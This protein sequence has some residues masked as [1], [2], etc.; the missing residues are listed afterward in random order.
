M[1]V[2]AENNLCSSSS[3]PSAPL[4]LA[5]PLLHC[6]LASAVAVPCSLHLKSEMVT[7]VID[8][9]V[10]QSLQAWFSWRRVAHVLG[11]SSWEVLKQNTGSHLSC[12]QGLEARCDIQGQLS[13][14]SRHLTA[15]HVQNAGFSQISSFVPSNRDR[16][17]SG[18]APVFVCSEAVVGKRLLCLQCK[19]SRAGWSFDGL[20]QG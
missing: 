20:Q 3:P 6:S 12:Y 9:G 18:D 10:L 8:T 14:H 16:H 5:R 1:G 13:L 4:C 19:P 15:P 11:T 2:S 7:S 17:K